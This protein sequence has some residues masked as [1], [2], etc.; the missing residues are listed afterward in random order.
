MKHF[1]KLVMITSLL[2]AGH[3]HAAFV[4]A[5]D[6]ANWTPT[7]N[8][9]SINTTGAPN[10]VVLTSS[11]NGGGSKNQDFTITAVAD[12]IVSFD[13]SYST[14]DWNSS[15]DPFGF[16]RNNIFTQLTTNNLSA[17]SGSF[18]L[19]VLVGDIFGFR[20]HSTDSIYG[21]ASTTISNFNASFNAPSSVPVPGALWLVVAP[22]MSLIVKKRK[23]A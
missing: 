10:S 7:S 1:V 11:D 20:A 16:L 23:A 5:Y 21:S 14:S 9:G 17:Q 15:Y 6:I 2:V 4:G 13:W 12:G 8:G 19:N 3:A 18:I 22:L